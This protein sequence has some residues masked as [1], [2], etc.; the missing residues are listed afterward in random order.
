MMKGI[1]AGSMLP[2]RVPI[3]TPASGVN[4]ME[5]SIDFPPSIAAILAPLPR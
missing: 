3:E 5:V 4:P 2:E 1:S